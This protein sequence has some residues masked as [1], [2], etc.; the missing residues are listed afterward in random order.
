[1]ISTRLAPAAAFLLLLALL[2]T[3]L[4]SYRGVFHD[5]GIRPAQVPAVLDGL[6]STPEA[7]RGNWGQRHFGTEEWFDR[8]YG[9]GHRL[10]LTVVRTYDPKT[11]FHHPELA[12]SYPQAMLGPAEQA[13]LP[14]GEP[15]RV[16]RGT[17]QSRDLVAYVLIV[18][19]QAIA[20][21][22]IEQAR[23]ALR[24]LVGGRR[25]M[26]LVYAQDRDPPAV[27]LAQQPAV[28]LLASALRH[29]R[30]GTRP[31]AAP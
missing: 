20:D 3:V 21:P 24:M 13:H 23:L 30:A 7:R 4:H 31:D 16:L 2:P 18:D 12:I 9:A 27:P 28:T 29:L 6:P 8:W 15:V 25:P 22:Y 17:D 14:A 10:R 5:D 19:G 26:T 11:V 1:M